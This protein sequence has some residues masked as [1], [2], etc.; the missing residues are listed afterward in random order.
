MKRVILTLL[1]GL[2]TAIALWYGINPDNAAKEPD[3]DTGPLLVTATLVSPGQ[4]IGPFKLTD[5][6]NQTFT[7]ANLLGHWTLLFFGYSTC[8]ETCPRSLAIARDFWQKLPASILN[9]QTRF[10]FVTLNPNEDKIENLK[11]FLNR[12]DARFIGLTGTETDIDLLAKAC[13]VYRFEDKEASTPT[14]KII[15][16]TAAFILIN[17]KGQLHALFTP[18]H[19][20]E[21]IAKDLEQLILKRPGLPH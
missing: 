15:D 19:D 13:R 4:R 16:H 14:Q 2:L 12:F 5:T 17:P 11:S 9:N 10:V 8:P 6:G 20:S 21:I 1:F 7:Q 3:L 18:P